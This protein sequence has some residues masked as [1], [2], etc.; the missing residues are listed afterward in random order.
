MFWLFQSLKETQ[1]ENM[2]K[3]QNVVYVSDATAAAF[4]RVGIP[5]KQCANK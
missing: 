5:R 2:K 3:M 1:N 4:F